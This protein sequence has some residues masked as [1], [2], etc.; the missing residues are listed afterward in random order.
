MAHEARTNLLV[1]NVWSYPAQTSVGQ[2]TAVTPPA[3]P[4]LLPTHHVSTRAGWLAGG[5]PDEILMGN[6]SK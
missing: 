1:V 5:E 2:D 3:I 4:S 6:W